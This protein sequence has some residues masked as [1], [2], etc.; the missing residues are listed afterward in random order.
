MV[1]ISKTNSS[2]HKATSRVVSYTGYEHCKNWLRTYQKLATN[3]A[4]SQWREVCWMLTKLIFANIHGVLC[5]IIERY[6]GYCFCRISYFLRLN[7]HL[8][9]WLENGS[10]SMAVLEIGTPSGFVHDV[11]NIHSEPQHK[12]VDVDPRKAVIY[13]DEVFVPLCF[14]TACNKKV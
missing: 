4:K 13:F 12:R 5:N 10:S 7:F 6:R 1:A 2:T 11:A 9:S 14:S 8:N 3:M